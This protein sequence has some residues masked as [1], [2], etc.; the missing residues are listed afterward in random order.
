M[1]DEQSY[2]SVHT[3][4]SQLLTKESLKRKRDGSST[5]T[6]EPA[7]KVSK[8]RIKSTVKEED[9]KETGELSGDAGVSKDSGNLIGDAK[10]F[11]DQHSSDSESSSSIDDNE[12]KVKNDVLVKKI[13]EL[14]KKNVELSKSKADLVKEVEELKKKLRY[15]QRNERTDEENS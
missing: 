9:L 5:K 2:Q 7:G 6:D 13:K 12:E 15:L 10:V 4:T 1:A 8:E 11:K 3:K 14:E